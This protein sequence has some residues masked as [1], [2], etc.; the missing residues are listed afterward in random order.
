VEQRGAL[1]IAK[2]LRQTCSQIFR[3]AIATGRAKRDPSA[4][5]IGAMKAKGRVQHYRAMPT[6]DDLY[7]PKRSF[8]LPTSDPDLIGPADYSY[9]LKLELWSEHEALF[10]LLGAHPPHEKTW[11]ESGG[12]IH[13][14]KDV[15]DFADVLI[16]IEKIF[17]YYIYF[18][19][20]LFH[21]YA[22]F[23]QSLPRPLYCPEHIYVWAIEKMKR[24]LEEFYL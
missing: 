13:G 1:E 23:S 24:V 20:F 3:Y 19:E 12:P 8:T 22:E 6:L 11:W 9:W 16:D 14:N 21:R 18:G 15:E 4:G 5:L 2:R 7:F 17:Q 10:L